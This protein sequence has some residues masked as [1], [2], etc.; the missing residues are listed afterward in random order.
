VDR[1]Q[2]TKATSSAVRDETGER[3]TR[4]RETR[5]TRQRDGVLCPGLHSPCASVSSQ[6]GQD[7]R[8]LLSNY[9]EQ[10]SMKNNELEREE[11]DTPQG[12][13]Q[14][15]YSVESWR[16]T[17]RIGGAPLVETDPMHDLW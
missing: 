14:S 5:V 1:M 16:K 12:E 6:W 8:S 7:S 10:A 4:E 17:S 3:E 2:S 11:I 15:I 13:P 9:V